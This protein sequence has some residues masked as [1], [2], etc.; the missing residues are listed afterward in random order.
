MQGSFLGIGIGLF[1][2]SITSAIA[3]HLFAG[4]VGFNYAIF[5]AVI[6]TLPVEIIQWSVL[7]R[8][9]NYN[10][11]SILKTGSAVVVGIL[12][13]TSTGHVLFGGLGQLVG[14][15]IGIYVGTTFG[16]WLVLQPQFKQAY[17]WLL[18]A[19]V[20]IPISIVSGLTVGIIVNLFLSRIGLSSI[21]LIISFGIGVTVGVIF[22][23]LMTGLALICL[24]KRPISGIS[25]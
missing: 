13:G 15:L 11:W 8:R 23:S 17:W 10:F 4:G 1:M 18:V 20:G 12:L 3:Y 5:I 24:L 21:N 19:V 9:V 14:S 6:T 2:G 22:L 7:G 25:K 16:K